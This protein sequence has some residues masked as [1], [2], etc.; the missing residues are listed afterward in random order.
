MPLTACTRPIASR[1]SGVLH[2]LAGCPWRRRRGRSRGRSRPASPPARSSRRCR[3][4]CPPTRV[5][6]LAPGHP[7][8]EAARRPVVGGSGVVEG[9]VA[10][11]PQR[12][13]VTGPPGEP[14]S[15][16]QSPQEAR[17]K[18]IAAAAPAGLIRTTSRPGRPSRCRPTRN[19]VA[20]AASMNTWSSQRAGWTGSSIRADR[21]VAADPDA[22]CPRRPAGGAEQGRAADG[23][24]REP[25]ARAG[26]S[27]GP[28]ASAT[29]VLPSPGRS[30][31]TRS[32][33]PIR[34][35]GRRRAR[36]TGPRRTARRCRC[37]R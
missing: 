14:F 3:R 34:P 33:N 12:Y 21:P 5:L 7:P 4:A 30:A 17:A 24:D 15:G 8:Q 23:V 19:A 11:S 1:I 37:R 2:Q 25:C 9:E 27:V 20:P 29:P 16:C 31:G 18:E 22:R 35:P 28:P 13:G 26:R 32:A 6:P 10:H 36:G